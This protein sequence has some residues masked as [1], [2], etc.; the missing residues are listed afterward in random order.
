MATKERLDVLLL[1]RGLYPSREQARSAIMAG[2]V[3]VNGEPV[4]K[5]GEKVSV[6][7][8][9][10]V[11]GPLHPYVSRGGLKLERALEVFAVDLN[12]AVVIDVGASTG[13]FTDCAL[14]NGAALVYA[15]DVGYGQ[16]AWKL[17]QDPRVVVMERT[18]VRY[19][20]R[21]VLTGPQPS[22]AVM[23]VSFISI[24]LLLPVLRDILTD[25]AVIMTLIKPQ[26]EAG[27]ESVGKKGVVK[28]AAVHEDVLRQVL[29]SCLRE[30]YRIDGLTFSPITGGDGNI[31]FLAL[32]RKIPIEV[33]TGALSN[34]HLANISETVREAHLVFAKTKRGSL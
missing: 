17:R 21:E 5:A 4:I 24:R 19:L 11:K 6:V 28:E 1:E 20:R 7:G 27:K 25:D 30:S 9:I 23:D 26:F 18:N 32:L 13:G 16:L 8:E 15:V 14:M 33:K 12:S 22:V 10:V 3:L 34:E 2:L 31:E 29:A